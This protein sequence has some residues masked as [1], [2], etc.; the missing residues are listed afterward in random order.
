VIGRN[1]VS[2]SSRWRNHASAYLSHSVPSFP[3]YFIVGGPNSATGCGSLLII[4]ESIIGYVVKPVQKLAR[5][6]L[7]SIEV[8]DST[9][10]AWERY[11]DAYFPT[12]VHV[13]GCTSWYK[14]GKVD[15]KVV[16]LWPGSSLHT[17]K[18]LDHPRWEDFTYSRFPGQDMFEWLG[19]GWAVADKTKGDV[20][21]YLDKVD[22]PP[23]PDVAGMG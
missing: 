4:F 15:H 5:E 8:K 21:F 2:L 17:K 13:G 12:T 6:H 19:D 11:M 18:T 7:K 9:L 3:N 1:G 16:G 22:Y 23:P 14:A 10:A 20:S